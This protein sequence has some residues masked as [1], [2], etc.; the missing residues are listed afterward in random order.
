MRCPRSDFDMPDEAKFCI[1]S[2]AP[3]KSYCHT[4]GRTR[5]HG[6]SSVAHAA[7]RPRRRPQR[8][9]LCPPI[10]AALYPEYLAEKIL[11]SRSALEGDRKLITVL[12]ADLK[13]SMELLAHRDPE[14]ACQLLDPGLERMTAAMHRSEGNANPF[15][16]DSSEGCSNPWGSSGY[17]RELDGPGC[18]S[19]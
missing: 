13:G 8:R 2:G 3:V 16:G 11:S 9:L 7:H 14:E 6:P 5:S 15:A 12:F 17:G 10:N 1:E 18:T 19:G 4:A